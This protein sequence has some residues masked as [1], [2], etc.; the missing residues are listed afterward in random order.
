MSFPIEQWVFNDWQIDLGNYSLARARLCVYLRPFT[1]KVCVC[2]CMYLRPFTVKASS[3][4][5]SWDIREQINDVMLKALISYAKS[6][7]RYFRIQHLTF[8]T[9][10]IIL[11]AHQKRE[12]PRLNQCLFCFQ[13]MGP[14]STI[15]RYIISRSAF[16]SALTRGVAI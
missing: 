8:L 13:N 15:K 6:L 7:H 3:V 9:S 4:C 10:H 16:A 2:V 1:V 14:S 11:F 5:I 12:K